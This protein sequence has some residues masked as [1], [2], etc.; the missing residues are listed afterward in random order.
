[1]RRRLLVR[2]KHWGTPF[3][4]ADKAF[5]E[6]CRR[7]RAVSMSLGRLWRARGAS[8]NAQGGLDRRGPR[9][10]AALES[11]VLLRSTLPARGAPGSVRLRGDL[12][13]I[14]ARRMFLPIAKRSRRH[15]AR[16][17]GRLKA[18]FKAKNKRRHRRLAR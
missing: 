3:E 7:A 10:K 5:D 16:L 9:A 1:M 17:G 2:V 13:S 11:A 18:K 4:D 8:C 15:N 12:G 14:I 6:R